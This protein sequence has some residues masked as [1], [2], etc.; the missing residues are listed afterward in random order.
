MRRLDELWESMADLHIA[1]DDATNDNALRDTRMGWFGDLGVDLVASVEQ[2]TMT[3]AD[4][5]VGGRGSSQDHE[6]TM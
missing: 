2:P 5:L 3:V 4:L 1:G 6:E